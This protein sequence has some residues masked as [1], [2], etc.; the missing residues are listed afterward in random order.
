VFLFC[1]LSFVHE[2]KNKNKIQYK[3]GKILDFMAKR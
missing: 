2:R 1:V 3:G